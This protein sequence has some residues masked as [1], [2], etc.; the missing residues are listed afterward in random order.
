MRDL[1]HEERCY[2]TGSGSDRMKGAARVWNVFLFAKPSSLELSL[3]SGRYRSRFCNDS[4][5]VQSHESN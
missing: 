1:A 2:R 3:G 4:H 5:T